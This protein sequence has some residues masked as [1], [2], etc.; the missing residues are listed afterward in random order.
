MDYFCYIC[1]AADRNEPVMH[2]ANFI[3]LI[4][5]DG[6]YFYHP[7]GIIFSVCTQGEKVQ[8]ERGI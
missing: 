3:H 2:L 1:T 7:Y 4:H 6:W 8:R 5:R